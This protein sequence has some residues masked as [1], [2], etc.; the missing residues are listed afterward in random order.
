MCIELAGLLAELSSELR[1]LWSARSSLMA[2]VI[3]AGLGFGGRREPQDGPLSW[4][5]LGAP[6]LMG[7]NGSQRGSASMGHP[8]PGARAQASDADDKRSEE[9]RQKRTAPMRQG[10]GIHST[11][12]L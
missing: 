12:A 2:R 4:R 11:P 6:S 8:C 3:C 1:R 5:L 10:S 9:L 7:P